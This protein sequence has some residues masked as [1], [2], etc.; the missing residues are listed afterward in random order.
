[1]T[2][3]VET[4]ADLAREILRRPARLGTVRLVAVD[5]PSGAGKTSFADHLARAIR[6]A[7]SRVTVVHTDDLLDG[8]AD[9]FTFWP[10]LENGVLAPL[11]RGR[12]GKYPCYDWVAGRFA[13]EREVPVPDV[14]IL[15][16]STTARPSVRPELTMSVLVEAPPD[17]R[18]SRVLARDGPAVEAPL[19]RWMA[20]EDRYFAAEAPSGW[21]D[22]LVDGAPP[23][24]HDPESGFVRL[25]RPGDDHG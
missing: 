20:A 12:P 23:V 4:Y 25:P 18:L 17:E 8:W 9:Q 24:G 3:T 2:G 1:M 14:L 15:E 19:R 21:V 10:R 5:G 7:R 11:R 13:G 6:A 16:G 22:R